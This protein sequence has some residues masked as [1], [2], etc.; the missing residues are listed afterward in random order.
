[1]PDPDTPP[2]LLDLGDAALTVEFGTALDPALMAR[3]LALEAALARA[4]LPGVTE[5]VPTFRSLTILYD[6]DQLPREAL[7]A[8]LADLLDSPAAAPTPGR[9]WR[10]P[11]CYGGEAGPD[12]ASV[13]AR[14]QLPQEA[15]IRL[16]AGTDFRVYML[17]F[18]PGFPF[19]G[20]LPPALHLPRRPEPRLRVPAGSVAIATGLSAIYPWESPGGWHLIGHSPIPLFDASRAAPALLAPGDLVRFRPVSP[21][22]ATTIAA[23]LARG[24]LAPDSFLETQP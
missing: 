9:H 12:L 21:A 17:G 15:V 14:C 13:A 6:P 11:V 8:R 3:V 2:R 19:L 22:E 10:L 5:T 1:M 4:R 18:L 24:R 16:H 20:D 23:D 7:A